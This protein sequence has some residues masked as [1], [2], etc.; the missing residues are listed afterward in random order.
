MKL[1][2]E[3]CDYFKLF[4]SLYFT[5]FLYVVGNCGLHQKYKNQ[6]V[7][8]QIMHSIYRTSHSIRVIKNN[9]FYSSR[10]LA[11]QKSKRSFGNNPASSLTQHFFLFSFSFRTSKFLRYRRSVSILSRGLPHTDGQ[12][13]SH[14]TTNM[15]LGPE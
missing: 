11:F 4:V 15:P 5:Q 6:Q 8:D 7:K 10:T 3:L 13:Q 2:R 12:R 1:L 9:V 14:A